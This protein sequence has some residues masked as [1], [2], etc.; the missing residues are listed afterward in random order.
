MKKDI[1]MNVVVFNYTNRPI[2]EVL[3]DHKIDG[4]AAEYDGGRAIVTGVTIPLGP[5]TLTW[6]DAGSGKTF[7]VKNSLNLTQEQI[8]PDAGYLAIHI[9]SDETAELTFAKY[10]PDPTPRGQK[11]L[12][13]AEKNGK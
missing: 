10:L 4:G 3:L 7:K 5:Q 9:Y 6:R 1:V 12:D 13:E 11:I 2:F 8:P